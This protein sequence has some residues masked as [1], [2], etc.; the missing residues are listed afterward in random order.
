MAKAN[1]AEGGLRQQWKN[2]VDFKKSYAQ[3]Y[4]NLSLLYHEESSLAPSF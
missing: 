3:S 1:R 4:S 2:R